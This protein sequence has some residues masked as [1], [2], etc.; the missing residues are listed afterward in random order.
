MADMS[1]ALNGGYGKYFKDMI[2]DGVSNAYNKM[3][4]PEGLDALSRGNM[5][6]QLIGAG[7]QGGQAIAN[8]DYPKDALGWA[9]LPAQAVTGMAKGVIN[10][11]GG[12]ME[13]APGAAMGWND[14]KENTNLGLSMLGVGGVLSN[15]PRG[16]LATT[17]WN[18]GPSV[19]KEFYEQVMGSNSKRRRNWSPDGEKAQTRD[20]IKQVQS[21]RSDT[22]QG[23]DP[24]IVEKH[25]RPKKAQAIRAEAKAASAVDDNWSAKFSDNVVRD[26]KGGWDASNSINKANMESVPRLLKKEGW[27][28]RHASTGKTGN[29]SSRYVVSPDGQ[30]EVRLSDHY[31]PQT[32]QRE[33]NQAQY[34]TRW[35]DEIVLNGTERPSDIISEIKNM[36]LERNGQS[37]IDVLGD[38]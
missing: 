34:G 5:L 4:S 8:Y 33:F 22:R 38:E 23:V 13:E 3:S 14:G 11:I 10:Q 37:M 21:V 18:R 20:A 16:A 7:I 30:F 32:A 6:T 19:S 15:A 25:F 24:L 35:D 12:T 17:N 26:I 27:S 2:P 28:V 31:L 36:L 9:A 1:T 29:K